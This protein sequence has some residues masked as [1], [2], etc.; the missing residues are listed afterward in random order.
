MELVEAGELEVVSMS[1]NSGIVRRR[2]APP[3]PAR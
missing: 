3:D 1:E 2:I